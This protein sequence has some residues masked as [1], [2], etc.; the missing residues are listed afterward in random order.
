MNIINLLFLFCHRLS[1]CSIAFYCA[2]EQWGN[3]ECLN[4]VFNCISFDIKIRQHE[5]QNNNIY[6]LVWK[7]TT[8]IQ[9]LMTKCCNKDILNND[10][11]CT[12][13]YCFNI[14]IK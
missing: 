4:S 11:T 10:S 7:L 3:V 1:H 6:G 14:K 9:V 5:T 8:S 12:Q 2:F 13:K